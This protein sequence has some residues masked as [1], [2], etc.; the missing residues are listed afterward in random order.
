MCYR[1]LFR[2]AST[3][4]LASL[5]VAAASLG[6]VAADPPAGDR[7]TLYQ[8]APIRALLQGVY[9]GATT[10]KELARHGDFGL[11][12]VNGLDGEMLAFDGHFYQVRSDGTA[13]P[14]PPDAKTPFAAVTF[15]KPDLTFSIADLKSLDELGKYL[16]QHLPSPNVF[17]AIR[18]DGTFSAVLTRS[19]PRQSPP[20]PPLNVVTRTQ[21]TFPFKDVDG[22]LVGFRCPAYV[23]GVNVPG[24][25]FHF[26]TA[27][28]RSGGHVLSL[29]VKQAR[30]QIDITPHLALDLPSDPNFQHANLG[31]GTATSDLNQVEKAP[32]GTR[33]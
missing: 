10:F 19:V 31:A 18:I 7:E 5:A 17:Y 28:R 12:T 33:Q 20:Y 26:L 16:D 21:P 23:D 15:F 27:D 24:Y 9:D 22:T 11:G 2:S 1:R 6:P 32:P 14:V 25:H 4:A 13:H 8:N 3:H 29:S 30:V